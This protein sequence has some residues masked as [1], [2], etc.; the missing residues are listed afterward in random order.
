LLLIYADM[1]EMKKIN[2]TFG[3]AT[4]DE[5]IKALAE[6]LKNTFRESD[7]IARI[8]G[9]EF[10][11]LATTFRA[12]RER[13]Y[14]ERLKTNI[15]AYNAIGKCPYLLSISTG[16]FICDPLIPCGIEEMLVE[17]DKRMYEQKSAL[18]RS[19]S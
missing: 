6:I 10:A 13:T 3:H 16:T 11:I 14:M 18:Q 7:I 4:G 5:A 17:A 1:N 8:G 2:D 9:D 19:R 15:D 12:G